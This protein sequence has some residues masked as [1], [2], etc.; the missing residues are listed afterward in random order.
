MVLI[1]KDD[2]IEVIS[3]IEQI[4][5][6]KLKPSNVIAIFCKNCANSLASLYEASF[7]K[8]LHI[9]DE[10]GSKLGKKLNIHPV[11]N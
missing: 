4:Y 3:T 6:T 8:I 5:A 2:W 7:V 11:L 10:M 1:I 9:L